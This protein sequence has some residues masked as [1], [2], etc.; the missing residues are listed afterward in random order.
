MIEL[1]WHCGSDDGD[2]VVV[3]WLCYD[4]NGDGAE[5]MLWWLCSDMEVVKSVISECGE[6][7]AVCQAPTCTI[8]AMCCG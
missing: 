7:A 6:G 1:W 3:V 8:T 4:G 2:A 5:G